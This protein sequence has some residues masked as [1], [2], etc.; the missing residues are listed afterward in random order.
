MTWRMIGKPISTADQSASIPTVYQKF[1]LGG[2]SLQPKNSLLK[3]ASVGIILYNDPV[4]TALSLELWS[5]L[6][7]VPSKLLYSSNSY[8]KAQLLLTEDHAYKI[9]G[10]TFNDV[11]LR[12]QSEYHLVFRITGYTGNDSSHIAWRNSYPDPQYKTGL[13]LNAT[14]ADNMPLEFS[15]ITAE[16]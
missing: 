13:T 8:T 6:S 12:G 2:N 1:N 7:G 4:F 15:L 11:P 10:F 5:D 14:T 9:V 16:V 3:G